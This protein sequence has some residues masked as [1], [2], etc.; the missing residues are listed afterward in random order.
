MAISYFAHVRP[1]HCHV[2]LESKS[3]KSPNILCSRP[4]EQRLPTTGVCRTPPEFFGT[5]QI[6]SICHHWH[7]E[8][9]WRVFSAERT[10]KS[11]GTYSCRCF[12]SCLHVLKSH[13]DMPGRLDDVSYPFSSPRLCPAR[14]NCSFNESLTFRDHSQKH[15]CTGL[16]SFK[17]RFI[18]LEGWM[19]GWVS[20][21][22]QSPTTK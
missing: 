8:P 5:I 11:F 7:R 18:I 6:V 21:K 9:L 16:L 13:N 3:K 12:S 4:Q 15:S 17:R 10:E 20:N 22:M 1:E 14:R 19:D 2:T